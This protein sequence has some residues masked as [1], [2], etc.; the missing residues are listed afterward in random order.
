MFSFFSTVGMMAFVQ[1]I[2]PTSATKL[3]QYTIDI[4]NFSLRSDLWSTLRKYNVHCDICGEFFLRV[5][6]GYFFDLA[7]RLIAARPVEGRTRNHLYL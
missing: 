5:E 2:Q 6:R 4:G 3:Y 7:E 1:W